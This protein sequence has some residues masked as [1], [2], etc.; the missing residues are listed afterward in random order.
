MIY[1]PNPISGVL[2]KLPVLDGQDE[3]KL[4]DFLDLDLQLAYF[5]GVSDGDLFSLIY[6]YC[7]D[8]LTGLVTNT[9]R[10]GGS[11][12][13]LHGDV[14]DFFI[15]R[16]RRD[17]LKFNLSYRVQAKGEALA[18]FVHDIR[19]TARML[20]LGLPLSLIHI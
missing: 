8:S 6:T 1:V 17:Q 9:L 18:D 19:K 4:L 7:Q 13:S 3:G 20:R 14:L 2:Q 15:P 12:D 10:S 5:T 16:R 11:V